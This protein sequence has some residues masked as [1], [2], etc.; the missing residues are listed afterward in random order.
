MLLLVDVVPNVRLVAVALLP[1][2]KQT[3]R[4]PEDVEQLV[5]W[6][7]LPSVQADRMYDE[8]APVV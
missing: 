2:L 8:A 6:V 4:L 7:L 1:A 3:I 5:S